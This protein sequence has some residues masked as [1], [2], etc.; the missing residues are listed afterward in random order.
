MTVSNA[1]HH[2]SEWMVNYKTKYIDVG[3]SQPLKDVIF[4]GL[5]FSY[6]VS[7][8]AQYAHHKAAEEAARAGGSKH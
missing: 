6:V 1:K 3:S 7:W 4:Y 5:I 2:F 8:P